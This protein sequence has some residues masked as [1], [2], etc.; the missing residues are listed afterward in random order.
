MDRPETYAESMKGKTGV[1]RIAAALKYSADGI[2]AACQEQGF[3]QLLWIHAVLMLCLF[4]AGFT[5]PVKMVLILVSA[6]SIVIELVNTGI[7]A[8]VDHTS[9]E[10]HVLAKKA[11]DVGS[12][13]QYV[14]LAVVALLW[15]VAWVGS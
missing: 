10:M 9:Q 15:L 6:L 1:K 2:R 11:K 14:T 4:F 13:A 8:A 5:L 7:E 3:R 12:A